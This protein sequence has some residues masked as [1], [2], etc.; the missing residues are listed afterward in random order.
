MR[1]GHRTLNMISR[2]SLLYTKYGVTE[3]CKLL[4]VTVRNEYNWPTERKTFTTLHQRQALWVY[5]SAL[6]VDMFVTTATL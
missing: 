5:T 1:L 2:S 3:R 4:S 6:M